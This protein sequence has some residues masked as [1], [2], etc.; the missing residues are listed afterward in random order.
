LL[1]DAGH[2][3]GPARAFDGVC[4][5]IGDLADMEGKRA[6]P[7]RAYAVDIVHTAAPQN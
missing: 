1:L 6:A 5:A 3:L 7:R 2:E 4:V